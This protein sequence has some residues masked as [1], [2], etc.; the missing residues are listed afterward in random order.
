VEGIARLPGMRLAELARA[1]PEAVIC[2][3]EGTWHAWIPAG[4]CAGTE[5]HGR[6]EAELA[7]KLAA[8][9]GA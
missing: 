8:E 7:A 6:D 1:C 4:G 3:V 9:L 2:Q 5:M